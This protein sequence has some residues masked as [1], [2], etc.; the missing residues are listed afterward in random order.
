MIAASNETALVTSADTVSNLPNRQD[1]R[2]YS[3]FT[4]NAQEMSTQAALYQAHQ[5]FQETQSPEKE[6]RDEVGEPD[7]ST[8]MPLHSQYLAKSTPFRQPPPRRAFSQAPDSILRAI[9]AS[10]QDLMNAAAGLTFSTAKKPKKRASF[11]DW[12]VAKASQI[13]STQLKAVDWS[14]SEENPFPAK[15]VSFNSADKTLTPMHPRSILSFSRIADRQVAT[16]TSTPLGVSDPFAVPKSSGQMTPS[17]S[18]EGPPIPS[19]QER[20]HS[21]MASQE[22]DDNLDDMVSFLGTFDVD[23]EIARNSFGKGKGAA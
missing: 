14:P 10:T 5:A 13:T 18:S 21:R 12:P 9:P 6:T 1:S 23:K 2:A 11:A 17:A 19:Y 3:T 22:L 7:Q 16:F 4:F 8:I 15:A 20:Q